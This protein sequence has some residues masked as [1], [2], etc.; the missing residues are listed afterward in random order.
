[1]LKSL[2][3]QLRKPSGIYGRLVSLLLRLR[4]RQFYMRIIDEL[5]LKRGDKI[6][7]IGYGPGLGIEMIAKKSDPYLIHGIDFSELMYNQAIRRNKQFIDKGMVKLDFGDFLSY[8][9]LFEKYNKIFCVNVIYFWSDLSIAFMKIFSLLEKDGV[10]CIYMA[11][12][13]DLD[14]NKFA[15][16][17]NK[18]SIEKVV[19]ELKTAGFENVSYKYT[20]GYYIKALK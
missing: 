20:P 18:Y 3:Q 4:N 9:P 15:N 13:K 2:G 16:E 5:K 8:Q 12:A 17:F 10:F 19:S 1:M 14:K 7:E 6:F 11:H